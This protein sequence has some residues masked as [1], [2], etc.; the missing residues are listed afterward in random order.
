MRR[1][2]S[3]VGPVLI[4]SSVLIAAARP[5]ESRHADARAAL[6]RHAGSLAVPVTIL[7]ETMA[8]LVAR[9]GIEQQRRFWDAFLVSGI[10]LIATDGALLAE[11]REI[12][13]SY[14]DVSF[15]FADCTLLAACETLKA[16]ALL[17]LD[18]RLG[19]YRPRYASG[20]TIEP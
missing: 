16:E 20:M 4:D 5:S 2:P 10:E 18:A 14:A 15:G 1:G 13:R 6:E 8:F 9:L 3:S 7:S 11:A 17:T 19:L 12:D